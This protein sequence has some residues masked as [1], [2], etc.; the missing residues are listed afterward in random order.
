MAS[1]QRAPDDQRPGRPDRPAE[2]RIRIA[3]AW[4][5]LAWE[6]IWPALWPVA[7]LL[8]GLAALALFDILPALPGWLHLSILIAAALA[9]LGL[10]ARGLMGLKPPTEAEA[11]R[12]LETDSGLRHRPLTALRDVQATGSADA[13]SRTLWSLHQEALRRAAGLWRLRAPRPGVPARDRFGA[14]GLVVLLLA[15]AGVAGW[16]E[17]S[18]RTARAVTP[19]FAEAATEPPPVLDLFITP[20]GYTGLPPLYLRAEGGKTSEPATAATEPVDIPIGSALLARVGG[21]EAIP[22][23]RLAEA[24]TPFASV[25]GDTY[26]IS[27]A[28]TGGSAIAV[29][30]GEKT[31]GAWPIRVIADAAPEIAFSEPPGAT[32]RFALHLAYLAT[33]DYGVDTVQATVTLPPDAPEAL[34]RTPIVI[35]L[36]VPGRLPREAEGSS[37]H[38]LTPHPWAGQRV[39]IALAAT[40]AAGQTGRAEPVETVLPERQFNHPVARAII[41]QR[42]A[43]MLDPTSR[44]I[45]AEV[46]NDLSLRPDR[47]YDDIVVFLALRTASRRLAL[48]D[49]VETLVEPVQ[50]LLW[51]TALRIEDG[52]L[53]LAERDL[54]DAQQAL[55]EALENGASDERIAELMDELRQALDRYLAALQ[56]QMM[57]RLARGEELQTLPVTPENAITRDQLQEMLD[58]MQELSE[59]GARDAARE[60][61]AQMQEMLEN[62]QNGQMAQSPQQNQDSERF[63]EMMEQLQSLTEAQRELLDQ[64]F[65]NSQQNQQGQQQGQQG[66]QGQSPPGQNQGQQ[67][68]RQ[69]GGESG[70]G[71]GDAPSDFPAQGAQIQEALRRALGEMMRQMGEMTGGIPAPF[72]QAE[73]AMRRSE[74][75]LGGGQPGQAVGPQTE[76]LD[77]LQQGME[78]LVDQMMEQMARQGMQPRP[79]QPGQRIESGRDPLGRPT[80]EGGSID[81]GD[82]RIPEEADIQ[83]ARQI[84]DELRRRL[85]ERDRPELEHDYIERLLRRF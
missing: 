25:D 48:Q 53:S 75:A 10:G 47:Y 34:D 27:G 12:R 84:L 85:G 41:D 15:L 58:R 33:D 8:G 16:G 17:W 59:T 73:Q 50:R 78:G 64:T 13:G 68:G 54:R 65:R 55:A 40:D 18:E 26:E 51:D 77:Q 30:Q 23:L 32:E 14:S 42:R 62:L 60:M 21:G 81:S 29:T 36:P 31:L 76:A 28:V 80:S 79:G 44:D 7:L 20:P 72:G 3:G 70:G 66:Q 71:Q 46:L 63:M 67:P 9:L 61:L 19:R 24:L 1:V 37:Y 83:R 5:A 57:E 6:R 49:D 69:P 2:P 74:Q 43:L 38:D 45:V 11:R 22:V 4:A 35:D 52:D 56:Q 39:M 82:V